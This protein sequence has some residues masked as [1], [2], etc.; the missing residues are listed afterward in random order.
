MK[1]LEMLI[2]IAIQN[3]YKNGYADPKSILLN[4]EQIEHLK[5]NFEG[6]TGIILNSKAN[7]EY[8]GIK[9]IEAKVNRVIVF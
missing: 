4:K 8:R 7:I 3:H 2:D 6:L 1:D 5:N 9:I